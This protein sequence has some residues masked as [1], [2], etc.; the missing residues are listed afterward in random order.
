MT[1]RR[2]AS[3]SPASN[4][5]RATSCPPAASATWPIS[6]R[7]PRVGHAGSRVRIHGTTRREPAGAV[8][9]GAPLLAL[10]AVRPTWAPGTAVTCTGT[11]TCSSSA[12]CTRRRSRWWARRC[13]CAPPTRA[14]ACQDYR[15]V[16]TH[17]ARRAR[18]AAHRAR[19]PAAE[20]QA[21]FAHDRA[22]CLQQ[23]ERIGPNLRA[24]DRATARRP[25][26]ER[27]RAAQGVLAC[28]SPMAR[29]PGGGLRPR[30][31]ARQPVLPHRQDHPGT[32]A[33]LRADTPPATPAPYGRTRFTRAPPN[34]FARTTR[35]TDLLH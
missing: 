10:P 20:A 15:H 23:A 26:L 8:R 18:R 28:S 17:P 33:D 29:A 32:G 16:A 14:V 2:R 3:S 35:S 1:R 12:R 11:A 7:R 25:H 22:W 9:A 19:S 4:T 6:T 30:A 34:S 31:G 13:G 21:F 27:L 5:S 24:A